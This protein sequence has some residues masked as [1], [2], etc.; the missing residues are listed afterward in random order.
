MKY[1]A[2]PRPLGFALILATFSALG[3]F[4]VDMYLASLPQIAVF[5]GTSAAAVQASLTTSLL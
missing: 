3:P 5:F 1:K 4:T 2:Q